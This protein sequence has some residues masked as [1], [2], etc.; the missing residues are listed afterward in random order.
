MPQAPIAFGPSQQSGSEQLGGAMPI[1]VN[2]VI[3]KMGT[4]RRRPGIQAYAGAPA[5]VVD[6]NGIAALHETQA[7][8]LYAVGEHPTQKPVYS[9]TGGGSAEVSVTTGYKLLGVKRPVIAETEAMLA[10]TAGDA[11]LKLEFATGLTSALGGSP[12]TATHVAANNS[13]LLLNSYPAD[14]GRIWYSDQAAGSSITGHETWTGLSAGFFS[15][16]ARPDPVVALWENTNEVFVFGRTSLQ[17]FSPDPSS[18]YAPITTKENGCAAPY[19]IVKVDQAFAWLDH[20]RRFV[21]SDGRKLEVISDPIK[22]SL[23]ELGVVDDCVGY[24]VH[25]GYVECLVWTF[26]T[27][28]RTFV[29]QVGAAWAQWACRA[30]DNWAP[31][32]VSA[33]FQRPGSNTNIVGLTTGRVA[34]LQTNVAADLG[35]PIVAS[36]T[37]GFQDR[38][39]SAKKQCVSVRLTLKRGE[40]ATSPGP[41]G[42]LR[43]RDDLGGWST[44]LP[45]YFGAAGDSEPVVEFRSLGVYRR[46]QWQFEF[47]GAVDFALVSAVEEYNVLAV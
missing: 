26:P 15:G 28:G 32:P 42:L 25:T 29:F 44:S 41:S 12:P 37:T 17:Y 16:E 34:K 9:V 1:A 3:D 23:D 43:W 20:Q 31:F 24:R 35:E 45:V 10:M 40:S 5:A 22:Q 21:L 6:A 19:S 38:G 46:R 13:R 2:V 14:L 18:V 7:G 11:P 8:L 4:I 33:H 30:N 39:T 47:S 36:A 27:D